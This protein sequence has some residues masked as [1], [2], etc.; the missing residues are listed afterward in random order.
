MYFKVK[1]TLKSNHNHTPKKID[2]FS[3]HIKNKNKIK[4]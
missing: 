1:S 4:N 2:V 3:S